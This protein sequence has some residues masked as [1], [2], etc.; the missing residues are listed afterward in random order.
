MVH[1][2][3]HAI[4]AIHALIACG[5][6]P[7]TTTKTA[8]F[9]R[10]ADNQPTVLLRPGGGSGVPTKQNQPTNHCSIEKE[11]VFLPCIV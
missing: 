8:V 9:L 7:A 11:K 4:H 2:C 3:M 6:P 5:P 10:V 1:A